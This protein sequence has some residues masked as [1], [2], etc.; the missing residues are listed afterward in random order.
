MNPKLVQ[1][2]SNLR[3]VNGAKT[4]I[5]SVDKQ[6]N[7]VNNLEKTFAEDYLGNYGAFLEDLFKTQSAEE[8]RAI[9]YTPDVREAEAKATEYEEEMNQ[10]EADMEEVD[11]IVAEELA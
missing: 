5:Y 4:N 9:I 11:R 7:R 3:I 8:I 10:I 6:G 1:D 2:T